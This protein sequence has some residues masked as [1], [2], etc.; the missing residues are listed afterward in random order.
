MRSIGRRG[1]EAVICRR[2]EERPVDACL[3]YMSNA[4]EVGRNGHAS[5]QKFDVLAC[6]RREARHSG[7]S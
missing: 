1:L 4:K 5:L 6:L 2:L 3:L 7:T